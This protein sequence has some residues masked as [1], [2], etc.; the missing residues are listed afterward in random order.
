M[1]FVLCKSL[2]ICCLCDSTHLSAVDHVDDGVGLLLK[3]ALVQRRKVRRV[4]SEAAVWLDDGEREGKTR[5]ED[6]LTT[7]VQ[8]HEAWGVT[9]RKGEWDKSEGGRGNGLV[10]RM[11]N[12]ERKR[13]DGEKEGEWRKKR[14]KTGSERK[15]GQEEG[16]RARGRVGGEWHDWRRKNRR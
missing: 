2:H 3:Q 14:K 8:L 1:C 4:I 6:D 13:G 11:K 10:G 5:G 12:R 15:R 16:G 7:L 9:D